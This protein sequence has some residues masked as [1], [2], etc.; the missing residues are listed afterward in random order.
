LK[1][2]LHLVVIFSIVLGI[3]SYANAQINTAEILLEKGIKE[4]KEENYEEALVFFEMA[5]KK[6]PKDP[7]ITSYLGIVHREMQNYSQAV[8]FFKETLALDPKAADIKFFLA[9][10]LIGMGSYEEALVVAD[11][12]VR[13]NIRP[14]QSYYLK[15][16]ILLKLKRNDEAVTAFKKSKELDP[17]LKQQADFQ[18]ATVYMQEKEFKQAKEIFKGLITIDPSSDWA[19]FSKDLLEAIEKM[20]PPYRVVLGVGVQYDTNVLGNPIDESLV[21]ITTQQDWKK[22]YSLLGEYTVYSKGPW[23][24]KAS[25]SLNITQHKKS[26]YPKKDSDEKVFSQDSVSQTFSIMPSYNTETSITSLLLSYNHLEVDYFKYKE[27]FTV[28]PSFTF[29]IKGN[30]LGQV[31]FRY[32][33]DEYAWDYNKRKY[34]SYLSIYED[35]DAHNLALGLGYIYTFKQGHGLFNVKVEGDI[36]DAQGKNWDYTGVKASAGL[37]YPFIDNKLKVNLFSEVYRQ[38][39]HNKHSVYGNIPRNT[40][41]DDNYTVQTTLTYNIMKPVDISVGYSYLQTNSNIAVYEYRKNLY[42]V[43]M[44]YRF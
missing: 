16:L 37:L 27:S 11:A 35:R 13:E 18:I 22:I 14:A 26:D 43:S 38:N 31:F 36:N 42:T 17:A 30:N 28:N 2:P 21:D 4:F 3:A 34:G 39:Y 23:N 32:R 20:P 8:K 6:S 29:I 24:I 7:R 44:E 19:L 5:Y 33:K 40:R 9:D 12:A 25:Y 41:K 10:T 1:N 15:G